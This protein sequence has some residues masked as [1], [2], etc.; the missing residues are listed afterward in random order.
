MPRKPDLCL[1]GLG[2]DIVSAPR[3][4]RF[5]EGRSKESLARVLAPSEIRR[6]ERNPAR[7]PFAKVFTAKEAFF[8]ASQCPP[9]GVYAFSQVEVKLLPQ[10]H[11]EIEWRPS[12][13]RARPVRAFGC[14]FVNEAY[15]GAEL[16][17]W[18]ASSKQR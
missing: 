9:G 2:V 16:I 1:A 10:D 7:F 13:S 3:A 6:F 18:Q 5:L 11:F 14:H 8:K 12:G 15:V 17:Y 4:E